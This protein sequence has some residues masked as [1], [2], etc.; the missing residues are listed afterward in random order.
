MNEAGVLGRFI[1]DFGRIVAMATFNMYHRFTIDEHTIQ[2][3]GIL[4]QIEKGQ[5]AEEHPLSSEIIHGLQH[6]R[7]L[8]VALL[9]HDVAKAVKGDHSIVGAEMARKLALRMGLE[10][11]R[12]GHGGLA[13]QASPAHEH[14]RPASRHFRSADRQE[15]HR[16]RAKPRA[17]EALAAADRRRYP[18]GWAG[19][20]ERL[21]RPAFA[22]TLLRQ[23][24]RSGWR[25]HPRATG[26]AH[27]GGA[28]PP[29]RYHRG[30]AASRS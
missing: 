7:A 2:A 15:V 8:Y 26:R 29:A 9:T 25:P 14:N 4:S 22:R 21:E 24:A 27:R 6:R 5:F 16:H 12:G 13:R 19:R 30:L 28:I 10:P 20:L 1:P 11:G 18:G 3:V 23:R 17:V